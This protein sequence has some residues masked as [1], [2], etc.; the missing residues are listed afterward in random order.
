MRFCLRRFLF[1][2]LTV[3]LCSQ[4]SAAADFES[5]MRAYE[6]KDYAA[7]FKEF[8]VVAEQGN[9]ETQLTVGKMYM[10]GQGVE[11]DPEQAMKCFKAADQRQCGRSILSGC[12][13]SAAPEGHLRR[14]EVAKAFRDKTKVDRSFEL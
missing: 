6:K 13:V 1:S 10:L 3:L 9:E 8:A 14:A 12:D 4:L 5:A 11:K 7:A 2:V